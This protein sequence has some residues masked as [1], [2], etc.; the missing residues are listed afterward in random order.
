[1]GKALLIVMPRRAEER[2]VRNVVAGGVRAGAHSGQEDFPEEET[3][4]QIPE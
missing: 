4:E 3:S 2:P 1:M